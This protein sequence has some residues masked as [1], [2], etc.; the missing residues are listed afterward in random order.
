MKRIVKVS[1]IM[2]VYN[3][4]NCV[5]RAIESI[6][7]Q[8]YKNI[9]LII[10]NDGSTDNTLDK[11]IKYQSDKRVKIINQK[12]KGPSYARNIGINNSTGDYIAFCDGDDYLDEDIVSKFVDFQK[13]KDYLY[14]VVLF[15]T[16]RIENGN[17]IDKTSFNESFSFSK[18][19]KKLLIDSIF[20][21]FLKYN[22]IFGF[23][24]ICGKF[25]SSSLI[26]KNC[27][28][29]PNNVYRFEDAKFCKDV[30][31]HSDNIYYLNETGYFYIK[32]E[33]SLSNKFDKN[34]VKI[35]KDALISLGSENYSNNN[36]YI[37]TLTTLTECENMYYLNEKNNK[38]FKILKNEFREMINYDIYK[39]AIY[40]VKFTS[41]PFHY[42]IEIIL[43]R[44]NMINT[45]FLLKKM[46][47]SLKKIKHK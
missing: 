26:K 19:E 41:V 46:H 21:K 24:G 29:Y 10:I 40:K 31:F 7:N 42:K 47:L 34:A 15:K 33:N 6:L 43:L 11:I 20:N 32:N 23:D 45:Y 27:I 35:F 18:T 38:K 8:T 5:I 2:P 22:S 1:F 28:Q 44:L 9:E 39:D 25:I 30:Y 4:S 12:N 13:K 17:L 16:V 36:F 37:K 3:C 14:D